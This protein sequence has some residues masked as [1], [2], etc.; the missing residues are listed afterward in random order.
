MATIESQLVDL[1]KGGAVAAKTMV[2]I[3]GTEQQVKSVDWD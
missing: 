2:G 3:S 1:E